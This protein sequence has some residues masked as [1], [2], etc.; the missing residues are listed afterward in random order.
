VTQ[1]RPEVSVIIP[2]RNAGPGFE[3]VLAAVRGQRSD[4]AYEVLVVDSGSSDGTPELARRHAARTLSIPR[5]EFNHGGTRNLGISEARGEFVAMIVQDA[6]PADESWL[7]ALVENLAADERVAGAYS[8]QIPRPDCNPFTRHGLE[9][10]YTNLPERREQAIGDLARYEALPPSRKLELIAFDDVSSCIRR[11]AWERHPFRQLS[12]GEDLEWSERVLKAGYR[13]VYEPRSAVVHSHNRSAIYEMK[14]AYAT[15]K[16]LGELAGFRALPSVGDLL[17]RLP[18]LVRQRWKLAEA[19]G[20]GRRL[21][22]QAV[23][24]SVGDQ[25]GVFLGGVAGARSGRVPGFV[26]R[27]LSQG[28]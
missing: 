1:G 25:L 23:T 15:H 10:H 27:G 2:T 17:A 14:R 28:V 19:A 21:Y 4:L 8:R 6:V 12:F 24:R 16:L 18:G 5:S 9:T 11:S 26:D 20:G 22:A 13:I 3:E 7:G